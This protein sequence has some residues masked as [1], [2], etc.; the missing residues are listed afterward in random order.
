MNLRWQ[1][2]DLLTGFITVP[3][4][5][6]GQARRVPLN[7]IVRSVLFD[8]GGR[9][10]RPDDAGE[11]VFRPR[12]KQSDSFFPKAVERA[13]T[14]L[15]DRNV[16]CPHLDTYVWHSNRHTF[17]S[18]LAMAGVP[19]LTIKELGGWKTMVMVQRYAHLAPGHLHAAV[20]RLVSTP[21]TAELARN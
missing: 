7:S 20:E 19:P 14:A 13:R 1:D 2:I 9:R 12:P 21:D 16:A 11:L 17:A 5:K 10:E 15:R 4:S 3:Q 18:R 6:H 8:L